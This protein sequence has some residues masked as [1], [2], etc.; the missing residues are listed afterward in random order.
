MDILYIS[1]QTGTKL[2]QYCE[3]E[4]LIEVMEHF[5]QTGKVIEKRDDEHPNRWWIVTD[6]ISNN[7]I[8]SRNK[9]AVILS[10][11]RIGGFVQ[12]GDRQETGDVKVLCMLNECKLITEDEFTFFVDAFFNFSQGNGVKF[13][14]K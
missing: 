12:I 5:A 13:S 14:K 4:L 2:T 7:T 9:L 8:N 11:A 6:Y 1:P 3:R 10:F